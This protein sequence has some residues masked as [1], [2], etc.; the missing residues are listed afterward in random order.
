MTSRG[1]FAVKIILVIFLIISSVTCNKD[2]DTPETDPCAFHMSTW[3]VHCIVRSPESGAII[4]STDLTLEWVATTPNPD[5][6]LSFGTNPDNL[7]VISKQKSNIYFLN[8]L[9]AGKYY[10][11]VIATGSC[12]KGC[13]IGPISFTVVPDTIGN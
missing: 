8:N 1:A 6:V 12:K 13:S 9:E 4:A 11:K 7:P 2:E 3:A 10:W 5:Y